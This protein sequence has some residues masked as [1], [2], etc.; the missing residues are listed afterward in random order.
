M[1]SIGG[2]VPF[3]LC[4]HCLVSVWLWFSFIVWSGHQWVWYFIWTKL[5]SLWSVS[6]E[7]ENIK[8][9]A[10]LGPSKCLTGHLSLCHTCLGHS[11]ILSLHVSTYIKNVIHSFV[12]VSLCVT[13]TISSDELEVELTSVFLLFTIFILTLVYIFRLLY[14]KHV[15]I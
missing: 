2:W 9:I 8:L 4:E 14:R 6:F 13:L 1:V 15:P 7:C 3:F 12:S 11:I 5:I 10:S